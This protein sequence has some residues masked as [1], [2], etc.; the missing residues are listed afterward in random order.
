[1]NEKDRDLRLRYFM[2]EE[3][4]RTSEEFIREQ[5]KKIKSKK[6]YFEEATRLFRRGGGQA[7]LELMREGLERYPSDPFLLSYYGSLVASVGKDPKNGIRICKDSIS[8][9]EGSVPFGS[10]FFRPFFLLNLGRAYLASGDKAEALN[11]FTEGLRLDPENRDILRE[12]KKMGVRRR[13]PVSF[14]GRGNP[15][16]KYLGILFRRI[17]GR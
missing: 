8:L 7:A 15:I 13:S 1:M 14:L 3:H 4:G 2:R 10:D 9:L 6:E 12:W 11:V 5:S 17:R 16:N